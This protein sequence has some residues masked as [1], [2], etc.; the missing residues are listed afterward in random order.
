M[1]E[2]LVKAALVGPILGFIAQ[3]PF[4][5]HPGRVAGLF[6]HRGQRYCIEPE[7][8]AFED[9][10]RDAIVKFMAAGLDRRACGRAGG[11]DVKIRKPRAVF[12]ELIEVRCLDD[13][14]AVTGE[15]AVALII[16]DDQN[17]VRPAAG[18]FRCARL[19]SFKEKHA[20]EDD[21]RQTTPHSKR[22]RQ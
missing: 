6:E 7:P 5:E 18:K 8:F 3:M 16:G 11:A 4:A 10:M 13:R 20:A 12:V 2:H 17:D 21:Q 22:S 19:Y 14:I 15:V 9:C 1:D